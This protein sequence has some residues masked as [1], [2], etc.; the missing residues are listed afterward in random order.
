MKTSKLLLLLALVPAACDPGVLDREVPEPA[1]DS[2]SLPEVARLLSALP[3]GGEQLSEV[4]AAVSASSRNGY[5]EEYT[6]RDLFESPGA[7][8]GDRAGKGTGA[9]AQYDAPLRSL[10]ETYVR[11]RYRTKA[12]ET[13]PEAVQAYLDAL[14]A[15]EAQIYWPY[16][17]EYDGESLPVI[18]FDPGGDATAN[19]GYRT[20]VDGSGKRTVEEV[21]VDEDYARTH[22]VWVVNY[23]SDS[24]Y[25]SL[26][27]RR[28]ADP[29]WGRGGEVLV[30]GGSG[31]DAENSRMLVLKYFKM[32]RNYDSWFGGASE[33]FVK[34]GSMSGFKAKT[35]SEMQ[36]YCP[37]I[38][39]FMIVVKRKDLR[40]HRPFNAILISDWTDQIEDFCLLVTEDDGGTRT[41]W[42]CS[43]SA[44]VQSKS[45][46]FELD[47]PYHDRDD[48][49]WRGTLSRHFFEKYSGVTGHFGDV[50]LTF[51][52]I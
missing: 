39:D 32:N 40:S 7:G 19:V 23:N 17:E 47:I 29:D 43:A 8:V 27:M 33:F 28:R 24:G 52:I 15:S 51:G 49:V 48:I 10:I 20:R 11:E 1:M 12:G 35:E 3:I 21:V 6:M 22:P 5:D 14:A 50:E 37:T 42:K 34:C 25:A 41:S 13:D 30:K 45:Y 9:T 16:S 36:E 4:H 46:G 18:T 38:T 44:K 26:E 2:V 31:D